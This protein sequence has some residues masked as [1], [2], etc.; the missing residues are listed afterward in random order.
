MPITKF[1]EQQL[2]EK[3]PFL[4][5]KKLSSGFSIV[6]QDQ[7]FLLKECQRR[8][9]HIVTLMSEE[10]ISAIIDE[11]IPTPELVKLY[12]ETADQIYAQSRKSLDEAVSSQQW[13]YVSDLAKT[14]YI[15][16]QQLSILDVATK[17]AKPRETSGEMA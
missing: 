10:V 15:L 16:K 5:L 13:L 9:G 7:P 8:L 2:A 1:I 3:A 14:L 4:S 6:I 12:R 17:F 11:L